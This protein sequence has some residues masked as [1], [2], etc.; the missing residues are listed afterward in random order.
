MRVEVNEAATAGL[1]AI[2]DYGVEHIEKRQ[3][4]RM[5]GASRAPLR[6]WQSIRGSDRCT[7]ACA[8]RSAISV[9]TASAL[10]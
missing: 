2:Y 8:R 10:L 5:C 7:T 6:C 4:R 1:N 3:Q 9:R